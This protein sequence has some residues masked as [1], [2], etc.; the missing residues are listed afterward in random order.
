M[1]TQAD[2]L[3]VPEAAERLRISKG[4]TYELIRQDRLPHLHLGRRIFISAPALERWI[5]G[6]SCDVIPPS[7]EPSVQTLGL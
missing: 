3:T 5:E 2:L 7:A 6:A 1:I 4:L